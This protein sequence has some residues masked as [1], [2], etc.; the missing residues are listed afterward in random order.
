MIG[1]L[2]TP[3]RSCVTR[4]QRGR[5][6]DR[7]AAQKPSAQTKPGFNRHCL[8]C[9]IKS[10]AGTSSRTHSSDYLL[11]KGKGTMKGK[12]ET[13]LENLGFKLTFPHIRYISWKP[14]TSV[15][16]SADQNVLT[17]PQDDQR[18]GGGGENSFIT[19]EATKPKNCKIGHRNGIDLVFQSAA[20]TR[21]IMLLLLML[22]LGSVLK[23]IH[24]ISCCSEKE[25]FWLT[26]RVIN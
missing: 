14:L 23:G 26:R 10:R 11:E 21:L 8:L 1:R 17:C 13:W 22:P 6:V 12:S 7:P 24:E 16:S 4:G 3:Q 5:P 9:K 25:G 15:W 2:L 18:G 19:P 20:V